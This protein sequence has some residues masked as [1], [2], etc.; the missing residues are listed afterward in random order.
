M[1]GK[2]MRK[3]RKPSC[4]GA[5]RGCNIPSRENVQTSARSFITRRLD[6]TT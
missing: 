3:K 4:N 5:D 1:A 2:G 6:Q